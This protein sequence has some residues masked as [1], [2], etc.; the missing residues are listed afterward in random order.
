M[1][2][3]LVYIY[4][5]IV[6]WLKYVYKLEIFLK[7]HHQVWFRYKREILSIPN[8][9]SHYLKFLKKNLTKSNKK[10]NNTPETKTLLYL[11]NN[12]TQM[13]VV[14]DLNI[15]IY[16]SVCANNVLPFIS[17][18]PENRITGNLTGS[19]KIFFLEYSTC[20]LFFY[21]TY[22]TYA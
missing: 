4:E 10:T 20:Y 5:N 18:L 19:E 21:H 15:K 14:T 22:I 17:L 6:M 9:K 2:C 8:L 13:T 3:C 7:T 16:Y 12:N 11:C 1:Y